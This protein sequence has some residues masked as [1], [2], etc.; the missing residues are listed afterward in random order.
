M[1]GVGPENSTTHTDI[2]PLDIIH[3][4]KV[5]DSP[6][7]LDSLRYQ[8]ISPETRLRKYTMGPNSS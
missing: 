6:Q 7:L 2:C 8:Y 4:F 1:S 5:T 3:T